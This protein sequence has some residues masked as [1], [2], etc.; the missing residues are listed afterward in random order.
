[1][2]SGP[3]AACIR[4]QKRAFE[5]DE[6]QAEDSSSHKVSRTQWRLAP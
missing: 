3:L 2:L 4:G 6:A 5:G 1:M